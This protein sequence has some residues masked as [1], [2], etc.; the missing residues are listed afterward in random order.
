MRHSVFIIGVPGSAKSTIWKLLAR[1]CTHI[2]HETTFDIVDPKCVKNEELFGNMNPKTKEWKDGVL[3]T[4]MRD[5]SKCQGKF[6]DSQKYKWVILDGDVDPMWIE[7]MN[8]VMDDNKMLT[9]V[10]QE[11]IPLSKSMR[12][13]LEVSHL[14]NATPATV[15]RG[16]VLFVNEFDIGWKPYWESW[17]QKFKNQKSDPQDLAYT[18]FV[19]NLGQYCD[20]NFIEEVR[21]RPAI[22][23][24]CLMAYIQSLTHIIDFMYEELR[25]EKKYTEFFK[26][27]KDGSEPELNVRFGSYEEAMKLI[28][29]GVFVFAMI[30]SFGGPQSDERIWFSNNIKQRST[31]IRFPEAVN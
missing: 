1:A 4:M 21:K 31:K 2:D 25:S 22:T 20:D 27:L 19:L 30:W 12:L 14:K 18:T 15:S 29:E 8:T 16:G 13:I 10:S 17:I 6:T 7:S 9:L 23:P 26:K 11:R 28:Y 5:M 3:S 24:M